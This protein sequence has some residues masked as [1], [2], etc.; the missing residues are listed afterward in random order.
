MKIFL[1][2][3]EKEL[4]INFFLR[5]SKKENHTGYWEAKDIKA[6][7]TLINKLQAPPVGEKSGVPGNGKNA[8]V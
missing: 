5:F 8:T 3:E 2:T 7:A 1:F 6:A 4:T